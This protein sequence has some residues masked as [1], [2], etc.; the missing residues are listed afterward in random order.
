MGARLNIIVPV[1]ALG[2][3]AA[4]IGGYFYAESLTKYTGPI[5]RVTVAVSGGLVE[6]PIFIASRR[7]FC[8]ERGKLPNHLTYI[9]PKPLDAVQP[10]AVAIIR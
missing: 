1:L 10:D 9:K 7:G 5:E 6:A 4:P 2:L 3:V 8:S